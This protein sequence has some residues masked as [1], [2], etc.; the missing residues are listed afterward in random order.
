[1]YQHLKL[2]FWWT[3]KVNKDEFHD[4]LAYMNMYQELV[5]SNKVTLKELGLIVVKRRGIAH[6]LDSGASIR[7]ISLEDIKKARI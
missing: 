6:D 3:Q 5:V 2:W 1:M 4:K 7:S